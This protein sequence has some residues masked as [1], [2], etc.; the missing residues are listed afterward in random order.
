MGN[1]PSCIAGS[2]PIKRKASA[3]ASTGLALD[4]KKTAV[5]D[6]KLAVETWA[7]FE[8]VADSS[9]S[10]PVSQEDSVLELLSQRTGITT[11]LLQLRHPNI[12]ARQVKHRI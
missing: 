7:P 5:D 8:V 12:V 11:E 2:E 6:G 1:A 4:N 10:L 9:K 3:A